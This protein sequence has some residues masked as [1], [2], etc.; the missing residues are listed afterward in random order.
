MMIVV[1]RG[2]ALPATI[3]WGGAK[4]EG[5]GGRMKDLVEGLVTL[6]WMLLALPQNAGRANQIEAVIMAVI[7]G[8]ISALREGLGS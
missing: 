7:Y 6:N 2:P 1:S 3:S 5:R 4:G 8:T